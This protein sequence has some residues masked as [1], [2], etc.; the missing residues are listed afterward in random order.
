MGDDRC[1]SVVAVTG[2]GGFIGRAVTACLA[3]HGH[4]VIG[5]DLPG[6]DVCRPVVI[7]HRA[8]HVI[9]LA[10]VLGTSELAASMPAARHAI[11]VNIAGTLHVLEAARRA[12]AGYTGITMPR[13]FP[14]VYAATKTGAREIERA[15]HHAHGVPVSRVRAFNAF[16]PWQKHGPGHPAKIIPTFACAAWAGQPI[17]V[18]GDGEQTVDLIHAGDLARLLAD[19]MEWGDDCTIDGGTGLALTVNQIAGLVLDITG[20][21]AGIEYL[22]MRTGEIPCK[23]AAEGEGW[24][25]LT[26]RPQYDARQ[27]AATVDWYR[28]RSA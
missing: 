4:E 25:R 2:A 20:S 28:T 19:A 13:A 6:T 10:G 5:Y 11:D 1:V 23:I 14:S 9:H 26:W 21:K 7:D 17:P 15:W 18:Y 8:A 22:P 16:G 12:G 3:E 24:D 27:V